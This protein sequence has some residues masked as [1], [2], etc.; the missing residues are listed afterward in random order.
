MTESL[1]PES[2]GLE[3]KA[4]TAAVTRRR[5]AS[6]KTTAKR[7]GAPRATKSGTK[8]KSKYNAAGERIDGQW[9]ASASEAR[10]YEQL[11]VMLDAGQIDNLQLQKKLPCTVNN[12]VIC[13]YLADF[14]YD[15]I[16]D[17]GYVV[18]SVIED[19]KGMVTDVYRIK[20]KLVEAI[21]RIE[22][23]E[24]PAKDIPKWEGRAA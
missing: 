24:I 20:K 7:G 19:V 10:R 9:F 3:T 12:I 5:R 21:Y 22:I 23:I 6:V 4:A 14:A 15:V 1:Q 18:R 8:R 13:N 17:R 16:D 2:S 11:K